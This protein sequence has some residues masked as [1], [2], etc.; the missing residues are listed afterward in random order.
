MG[1]LSKAV[2]RLKVA[3]RT[4]WSPPRSISLGAILIV[5]ILVGAGLL[6][7]GDALIQRTNSLEFCIS[8]HEMEATVYEE[9]K[10]SPHYSN[11]SGVRVTC[12]DCHVPRAGLA[13][14]VRKIEAA[15]DIYHTVV[16]TISTPEKFEARRRLLAERVWDSMLRSDSRECRTCH[17][18]EA[19]A[20]HK[21]GNDARQKMKLEAA[22]NNKSCIECHK[23][24]AHKFPPEPRDD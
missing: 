23:G 5:G 21:Q 13:K 10:K 11:P 19:M 1:L 17:S 22:P 18:Y 14:F 24:I 8:C 2:G 16:G 4:F 6:W 20:F 7:A 15:A 9:Y 3:W 12:S